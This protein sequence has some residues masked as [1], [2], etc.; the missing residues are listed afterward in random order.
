MDEPTTIV[1]RLAVATGHE[2]LIDRQLC[3]GS[4]ATMRAMGLDAYRMPG[5]FGP[6]V[7]AP[8][9]GAPHEQLAAFLGRNLALVNAGAR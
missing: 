6:E 1:A 4:L 3:H 8:D 2:Q 9:A 5:V 7:A